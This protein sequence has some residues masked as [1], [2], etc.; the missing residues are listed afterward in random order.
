MKKL[1]LAFSALTLIVLVSCS[2]SDEDP[3]ANTVDPSSVLLKKI[4]DLDPVHGN[5]T[6]LI[7][8]NGNKVTG[9][10]SDDGSSDVF[11][12]TGDLITKVE[13]FTGT[14]LDQRELYTY[15]SNNKLVTYV[16]LDF[17][18]TGSGVK[19]T[20]VHNA[21]GTI[22]YSRYL[23]D[24]NSQTQL[25]NTGKAFFTNG[26]ISKVEKYYTTGGVNTTQVTN[27]TYD[28]INNPLMNITGYAA[29]AFTDGFADGILHNVLTETHVS[30]STQNLTT[31]YTYNSNNFPVTSSET[32]SS[33][34]LNTQYFYE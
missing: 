27:Y 25:N 28:D 4:I 24:T 21:D 18:A 9:S 6:T 15:N 31:T 13:Y 17:D 30:N 34:T 10:T 20:Y 12:Y 14:T 32:G 23:G 5:V 7:N 8:Y 1:A 33:S 3:V 22:S 26:E 2:V 29:T 11:T 16:R 19:E